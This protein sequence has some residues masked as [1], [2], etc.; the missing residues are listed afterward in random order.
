M[1]KGESCVSLPKQS[2]R[3]DSVSQRLEHV[4]ALVDCFTRLAGMNTSDSVFTGL[5]TTAVQLTDCELSQLYLLDST[6]TRLTLSAQWLDGLLQSG[7]TA[8]LSSDYT[9]TQLL[10]YCLSQNKVLSLT[11]LDSSLYD[12]GFL[13]ASTQP[14]CSLLCVPLLDEHKH[15]R[16]VLLCASQRSQD[17]EP[18]AASLDRL[19]S[20]VIGQAHLMKRLSP[21]P[22]TTHDAPVLPLQSPRYYGLLGNSASMQVVYRL[23]AKTLQNSINVLITGETGSG[24]ELVARGIHDHG[25]RRNKPFMVQNC[26][27]LPS[28]LLESELFG[29]RK[30]AF[31]G[32]DQNRQ[33]LFDAADGG[34]LFLDEIGDM[35]LAVQAKLL[36]VLQEGEVRPLGSSHPHTVDVRIIAATHRNLT[37]MVEDGHFREDL[38]YRLTH[39]PIELPPLRKRG[40]DIELLA[41]CFSEQICRSLKR[42]ACHWTAGALD[43]L[44]NHPFRGNVRELK[45]MVERA[46]LLCEEHYLLPEHFTT[47]EFNYEITSLNLRDRLE[48]VE[49]N[50]LVT[51]LRKHKWHT[52]SAAKELGMPGRTLNYRLKR[53]N[54][55]RNEV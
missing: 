47:P 6:H 53:L 45:A 1:L 22:S 13:P 39:F 36:R 51:S 50:L 25:A 26:A 32:A 27:S 16:G 34:T 55:S 21:L 49:R 20:F 52:E 17:L 38:F 9:G 24:K 3:F 54:V 5:V 28:G 8:Y 12:T 42:E 33:G 43:L 15:P 14:W 30:G 35:P 46:V 29:Y 4:E 37:Q 44:L 31:T 41:R 19:G 10:Q 23:M 18:L 40:D 48:Q 2:S 7:E 11:S